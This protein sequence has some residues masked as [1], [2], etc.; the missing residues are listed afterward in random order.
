MEID[1]EKFNRTKEEAEKYYKSIDDVYCPYFQDKIIFNAKGIEHIKFKARR[2]ARSRKDQY[3]RLRLISLAPEIIKKSHTLQGLS[4]SKSFE[5][6]NINSRWQS[7]LRNVVYY[8][9]IAVIKR[10]R[11]RI[12]VKQVGNGQK[13]FWSIIPFWKMNNQNYKRVLHSGNPEID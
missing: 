2:K 9:F 4:E 12:V 11:I 3:V 5:Y 13:F 8:E 1:L 10:T 7:I 6:E